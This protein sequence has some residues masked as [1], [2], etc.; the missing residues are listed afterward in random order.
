MNQPRGR[1]VVWL[2]ILIACVVYVLPLPVDWRWYRPEWPLLVLFY[3]GLAMPHRVGIFSASLTGFTLDMIHGTALGAMAMG[4][5]VAMLVILLNYQRI[6]Q[7]DSLLQSLTLGLIVALALLV[8][9][10]LHNIMGLGSAGLA[11]LSSVPLSMLLWPFIRN[12]LRAVRRYYEV[13]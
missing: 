9:R 10:W 13:E 11:F 2:S 5:V 1:W 4:C 7:F 12:V 8:E 3:W 6:R